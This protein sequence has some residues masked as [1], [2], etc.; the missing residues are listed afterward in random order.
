MGAL[1]NMVWVTLVE[2]CLL[3]YNYKAQELDM[4]QNA[5]HPKKTEFIYPKRRLFN[6]ICLC[7]LPFPRK[8]YS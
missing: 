4:N 6:S 5:D 3:P 8:Y 2:F 1:R 7:Y